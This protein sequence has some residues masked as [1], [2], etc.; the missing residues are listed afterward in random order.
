MTQ[1]THPWAE[2]QAELTVPRRG[3]ITSAEGSVARAGWGRAAPTRSDAG[4]ARQLAGIATVL[5]LA[6]IVVAVIVHLIGPAIAR[7]LLGFA[8]PAG[9]PGLEAAWR[10]FTGNL[11][12]AAAPLAGALLLQ[13]ADRDRGAFRPGWALLDAI[14]MVVL[15]G[16]VVVVGAGFGGYGMRMIRYVLPHGPVELAGYCCALTG[17]TSARKGGLRG[18]LAWRLGLATLVLLALAAVLEATCAP[19]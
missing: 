5:T 13:L 9:P 16:N 11:R 12:L 15:V 14:I 8:F 7:R 3:E 4:A 10:I 17:Y 1:E 6:L 18:R 19:L 2:A